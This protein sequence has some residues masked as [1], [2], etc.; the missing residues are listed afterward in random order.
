MPPLELTHYTT[1]YRNQTG[2]ERILSR[3]R[4][5]DA[6]YNVDSQVVPLFL[7]KSK[8]ER[9]VPARLSWRN[10]ILTARRRVRKTP[11]RKPAE[12]AVYHD[13]WGITFM[14]D[15]DAADRRIGVLHSDFPDCASAFRHV[16]GLL[17]GVLCVSNPLL[18]KAAAAWPDLKE[19]GRI[20]SLPYPV[21]LPKGFERP[22]REGSRPFT[23][24]YN[25]PIQLEDSRVDR[26]PDILDRMAAQAQSFRMEFIGEGY[27]AP[28]MERQL[29]IKHEAAF[30]G[31]L[32][33]QPYWKTLAG[34]DAV[35]FTSETPG[36]PLTLL[37]AMSLGVI[38]IYPRLGDGAEDYVRRI[39]ERLAYPEGDLVAASEQLM[40]VSKLGGADLVNLRKQCTD[41]VK[42]HLQNNY[43]RVFSEF[44]TRIH[45][46]KRIS[47]SKFGK[48]PKGLA[49]W[50]PLGIL[51]KLRPMAIWKTKLG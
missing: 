15:L 4:G 33:G 51:N 31:P 22:P 24:G 36:L 7:R 8:D 16:Q 47:R 14:A 12:V 44:A 46:L 42:P 13:L 35:I 23:I 48:K 3:H 32:S 50:C 45:N 18:Q 38:P 25:G 27:D 11:S 40:R 43:F 1:R 41:L 34:W 6:D 39:D 17:D 19:E 49:D 5:S 20:S 2:V 37:D 10:S 26:V 29:S 30:H 21:D 9:I 28:E